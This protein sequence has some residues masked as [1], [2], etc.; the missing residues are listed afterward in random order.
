[1]KKIFKHFS[2][3]LASISA[4]T[5]PVAAVISCGDKTEQS[6]SLGTKVINFDSLLNSPTL[7][8]NEVKTAIKEVLSGAV[9]S[10]TFNGKTTSLSGYAKQDGNKAY[11]EVKKLVEA[12]KKHYPSTLEGAKPGFIDVP[13]YDLSDIKLNFPSQVGGLFGTSEEIG[14][15]AAPEHSHWEI[16]LPS[17]YTETSAIGEKVNVWAVP[18]AWQLPEEYDFTANPTLSGKAKLVADLG[19]KLANNDEYDITF[20]LPSNV[21]GAFTGLNKDSVTV[22][23]NTD[24]HTP[25]GV[26]HLNDTIDKTK[27]VAKVYDETGETLVGPLDSND[28]LSNLNSGTYI[29][30][31]EFK[32][33]VQ[34]HF[35][36]N[37]SHER[38]IKIHPVKTTIT[39]FQ[40]SDITSVDAVHMND[41]SIA[42]AAGLTLP[43]GIE[44]DVLNGNRKVGRLNNQNRTLT[45][46]EVGTYTIKPISV[47]DK[48][49]VDEANAPLTVEVAPSDSMLAIKEVFKNLKFDFSKTNQELFG[50]VIPTYTIELHPG[51]YKPMFAG[52]TFE[53]V[54]STK[55]VKWTIPVNDAGEGLIGSTTQKAQTV[56][57][58]LNPNPANDPSFIDGLAS[59]HGKWGI[60][61][62]PPT[63]TAVIVWFDALGMDAGQVYFQSGFKNFE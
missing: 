56:T 38:I 27:L 62:T 25:T 9:G 16:A 33:G 42:M 21:Y 18:Q 54:D 3:T 47:N 19:F 63:G 39:S 52:F 29:L 23:Q 41:G 31:I 8:T 43:E 45:N 58:M 26:I 20:A 11:E 48:I 40:N 12:I 36:P 61:I 22:T 13:T 44:L 15:P 5:A 50:M 34:G 6:S 30:K 37:A 35:M 53:M 28:S 46:V 51:V 24:I 49:A 10:I 17:L 14:L 57:G 55:A 1:M 32:D 7:K 2:L 4:I 60:K 59:T